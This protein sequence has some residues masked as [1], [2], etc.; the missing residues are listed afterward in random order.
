MNRKKAIKI[1]FLDLSSGLDKRRNMIYESLA[2]HY[3]I[4]ESDDPDYVI[5]GVVGCRHLNYQDSVRIMWTIEALVPDFNLC[6]YAIGFDH[7]S[8]GDRYFRSLTWRMD[9]MEELCQHDRKRTHGDF[10]AASKTRFCNYLYSNPSPHPRREDFFHLLDRYKTVDSAGAHLN[11]MGTEFAGSRRTRNWVRESIEFR[12]PYKFSIAFE[13]ALHDGYTTEKLPAAFLA[14]TVPIYWGNRLVDRDY[15]TRAMI[16]CHEY[17]SFDDV[18]ERV[19]ELDEDDEKW[20]QVV[21]QPILTEGSRAAWCGEVTDF[22]KFLCNIF[23]Q[24]LEQARRRGQGQ[25]NQKCFRTAK[26]H[27]ALRNSTTYRLIRRF[28]RF[29]SLFRR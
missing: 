4:E 14:D 9:I 7:I 2:R 17:D 16:N 20:R 12:K 25:R 18:V 29:S 1:K 10:V 3:D 26:K 13:N 23:D 22:E 24:P 8:F 28:W 21:S 5:Y 6:D 27:A 19:R 11:N 15:N